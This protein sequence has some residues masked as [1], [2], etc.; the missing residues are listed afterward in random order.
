M[1][2]RPLPSNRGSTR[3]RCGSSAGPYYAVGPGSCWR[4]VRTLADI[5]ADGRVALSGS[6][7]NTRCWRVDGIWCQ[8]AAAMPAASSTRTADQL[9]CPASAA[10]DC[11]K[12]ACQNCAATELANSN[13]LD[14]FASG[15]VV[16]VGMVVTP[17]SHGA[18][19]AHSCRLTVGRS[20]TRELFELGHQFGHK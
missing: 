18:T 10:N 12:C 20:P 11:V 17:C 1:A 4:V 3:A 5:R 6:D 14:P 16:S 7:D 15:A 13:Q 2:Q 8:A 9:R 19:Q